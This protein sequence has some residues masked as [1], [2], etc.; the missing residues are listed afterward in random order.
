MK[1]TA[2]LQQPL[3]NHPAFKAVAKAD[4]P[5]G[6]MQRLMDEFMG[7]T[8]TENVENEAKVLSMGEKSTLHALF[9]T[10]KP[11]EYSLYGNNKLQNIH[12]GQ[13]IDVSA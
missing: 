12:K 4:D 2:G 13:L 7:M 3:F 5:N 10:D 9:G 8:E 11:N 6:E 1:I